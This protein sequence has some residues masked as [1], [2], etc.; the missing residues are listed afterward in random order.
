MK[1]PTGG[2]EPTTLGQKADALPTEPQGQRP[3]SCAKWRSSRVACCCDAEC[4]IYCCQTTSSPFFVLLVSFLFLLFF[5]L[6]IFV[7]LGLEPETSRSMFCLMSTETW[8]HV[9]KT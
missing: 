2:F 7:F 4:F 5:M 8:V 3:K 9:L 1:S 6:D